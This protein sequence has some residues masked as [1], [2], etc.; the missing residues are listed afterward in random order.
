MKVDGSY[1]FSSPQKSQYAAQQLGLG[2]PSDE[3]TSAAQVRTRAGFHI[4][5][6]ASGPQIWILCRLDL[7]TQGFSFAC[8]A[9]RLP[10]HDSLCAVLS[11]AVRKQRHP[12]DCHRTTACINRPGPQASLQA[13]ESQTAFQFSLISL[14]PQG[15]LRAIEREHAVQQY[16][17]AKARKEQVLR[18]VAAME[19]PNNPLDS[20]I[21]LLGGPV[22]VA[23]MTGAPDS[24]A[25]ARHCWRRGR[26]ACVHKYCTKPAN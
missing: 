12:D 10:K 21:D 24:A 7:D 14:S 19:L 17:G 8:I 25:A 18:A 15:Q 6:P 16:E 9:R 22:A 5:L 23:E 1:G 26:V 11:P 3:A 20:L 4:C 13:S 2:S